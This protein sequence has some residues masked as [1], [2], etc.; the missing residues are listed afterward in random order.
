M[1]ILF[2]LFFLSITCYA[3]SIDL[4][5]NLKLIESGKIDEVKYRLNKLQ[6]INPEKEEVQLLDAILTEDGENASAKFSDFIKKFPNSNLTQIAF[7]R[8]YSYHYSIGQYKKANEYYSL[9][10]K[11][12]PDSKYL[13]GI[14]Y[15]NL[16]DTYISEE[17]TNMEKSNSEV[18]TSQKV[19]IFS[20]Q[21]GA[22]TDIHNAQKLAKKI[23]AKKYFVRVVPKILGKKKFNLVLLGK[24]D[25]LEKAEQILPKINKEFSVQGKIISE[26]K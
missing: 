18:S 10:K 26:E 8:L 11:N 14:E 19:F 7:F 2:A 6:K 21:V 17:K 25:S 13:S 23:K 20:I 9:L 15:I 3:Q 5:E 24:Y 4:Y 1:K 16:K 12:Y 22:F